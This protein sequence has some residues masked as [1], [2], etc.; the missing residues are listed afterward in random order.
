MVVESDGSTAGA[1][2]LLRKLV[3]AGQR[4]TPEA[5]ISYSLKADRSDH[6][7]F[8]LE[9]SA[10]A[11][12]RE[13]FVNPCYHSTCDTVDRL[14]PVL[15]EAVTKMNLAAALELDGETAVRMHVQFS[16]IDISI[17]TLSTAKAVHET[18]LSKPFVFV[19]S[20]LWLEQESAAASRV[21]VINRLELMAELELL[22][23]HLIS[24]TSHPCMNLLQW[25]WSQR[26][27][28]ATILATVNVR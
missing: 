14:S 23:P 19:L 11:L 2:T 21:E 27:T 5:R 24:L 12:S 26:R 13:S 17:A 16:P 6:F 22:V 4:Y 20:Q 10:S 18:Y 8:S 15:L 28:R 25:R 9:H 1:A 3:R 7:S